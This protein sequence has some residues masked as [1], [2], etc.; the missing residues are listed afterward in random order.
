MNTP[1]FAKTYT[2]DDI[3]NCDDP[4]GLVLQEDDYPTIQEMHAAVRRSMIGLD[5]W[6]SVGADR[7]DPETT[8]SGYGTTID[9]TINPAGYITRVTVE[10]DQG[11]TIYLLGPDLADALVYF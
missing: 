11:R 5:I 3:A 1:T 7:D 10:T 2:L 6:Y 4:R 8:D 9:A